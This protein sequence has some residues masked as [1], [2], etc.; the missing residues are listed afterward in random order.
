MPNW[1]RRSLLRSGV[2]ASVGGMV[3]GLAGC[4][5]NGDSPPLGRWVPVPDTLDNDIAYLTRTVPD[6]EPIFD[7]E[8]WQTRRENLNQAFSPTGIDVADASSILTVGIVITVLTDVDAD[9]ARRRLDDAETHAMFTKRGKYEI[10]GSKDPSGVALATG[11]GAVIGATWRPYVGSVVEARTRESKRYGGTNDDWRQLVDAVPPASSNTL[12]EINSPG[13]TQYGVIGTGEALTITD[14][15]TGSV[16]FVVQ[17]HSPDDTDIDVARRDYFSSKQSAE[18]V[19]RDT[20]RTTESGRL[21]T[22]TADV[23][24]SEIS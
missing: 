21:V 2:A 17:F 16:E 19:D 10:Y 23:D 8:F 12:T 18:G 20:L 11:E 1:T 13:G 9:A 6:D 4:A 5:G 15:T 7:A 14:E 3:S 22:L 24:P